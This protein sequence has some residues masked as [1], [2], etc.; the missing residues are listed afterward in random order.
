MKNFR[1]AIVIGIMC[2]VL[3]FGCAVQISSIKNESTVIAKENTENELR[4]QVIELKE[5]YN[6]AYKKLEKKQ[7]ELEKL[8]NDASKS[9][10]ISKVWSKELVKINNF[11]GLTS[12]KGKGIIIEIETGDLL[13]VINALNNAGAEAISVNENRI[14][15]NSEILNDGD[16]VSLDGMVLEKPYTIKAIGSKTLYG[17]ITMPESYIDKLKK[18]HYKVNIQESESI[19]IKKYEGIYNFNFAKNIEN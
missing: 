3:S 6:K 13:L 4:E 10:E 2:F 15:F 14:I 9:N 8:R 7:K 1:S 19:T 17:A 12:L 16:V 5:E 11:L 18:D